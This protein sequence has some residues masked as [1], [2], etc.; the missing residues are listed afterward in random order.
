MR[1]TSQQLPQRSTRFKKTELGDSVSIQKRDY[2][3]CCKLFISHV[4]AHFY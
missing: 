4:L 2:L 3:T 1:R